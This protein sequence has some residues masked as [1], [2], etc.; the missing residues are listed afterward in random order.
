M[1][2]WH[3]FWTLVGFLIYIV[4]LIFLYF[5]QPFEDLFTLVVNG[6]SYDNAIF[7]AVVSRAIQ[8]I[9]GTQDTSATKGN[10]RLPFTKA[11]ARTPASNGATTELGLARSASAKHAVDTIQSA[12]DASNAATAPA[13]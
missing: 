7:W 8:T 3:W 10:T 13:A 1:L 11:T 4:V 12:S 9:S 6:L 5:Y 2:G